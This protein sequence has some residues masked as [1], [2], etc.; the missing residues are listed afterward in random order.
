VSPE[1]IPDYLALVGDSADGFPGIAGIGPRGAA[2]LISRYGKIEEFPPQILSGQMEL[3][4]LFKRLA[5]LRTDAPRLGPVD[6]GAPALYRSL[7]PRHARNSTT[8]RQ[9]RPQGS[10]KYTPQ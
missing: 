1:L 9:T 3:A 7:Q 10:H 2:T 5:T 8:G 4:L 6:H